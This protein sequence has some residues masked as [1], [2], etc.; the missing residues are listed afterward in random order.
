[1]YAKIFSKI[2]DSSI[3]DDWH[4]RVVFQD[5]L[6]LCDRDG[7]VNMTHEAIA[8][9]T[10]VPIEIVRES[11]KKLES[12]DPQTN[13]PTEDGRRLERLDEHR[14]W[15]WRIVNY[16]KYRNIKNSEEMRAATRERVKRFRERKKKVVGKNGFSED[17]KRV[18]AHLNEKTS[19][20]FRQV[21]KTMDTIERRLAESDVT[22]DGV[23]KMVD[24]QVLLWKGDSKME[25]YLRPSTLFRERN[26]NEYYAARELP[27]NKNV[28]IAEKRIDRSIGT[29]NEGTA[30]LYK[31]LGKVS[32]VPDQRRP[33]T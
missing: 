12:A 14:D 29:A 13:T 18:L 15:G 7:I 21:E 11:I 2:F 26:F 30:I 8:R 22:V 31:G 32:S 3:A 17:A 1:M 24:R 10:N 5:I 27:V 28:G 23:M 25:E 33:A 16:A 4:Q 20:G 19:R 6:I 9:R